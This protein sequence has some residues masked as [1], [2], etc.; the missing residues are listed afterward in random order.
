MGIKGNEEPDRE[1][2]RQAVWDAWPQE[3]AAILREMTWDGLN[4]CWMIERYGIS[5]G[6][7]TD[8]YVHS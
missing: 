2:V 6:I 3:G 7:E 4:G 8:G 1:T 5:I